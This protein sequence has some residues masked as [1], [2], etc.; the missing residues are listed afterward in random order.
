MM[1]NRAGHGGV[2]PIRDSKLLGGLSHNPGQ[3]SV[4]RVANERAQMVNDVMIQ[5]SS[6]PAHQR[7]LGGVVCGRREDVIHAVVELIA[8]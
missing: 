2:L 7:A 8:V 1:P 4:V 6:E 5:A 3:R